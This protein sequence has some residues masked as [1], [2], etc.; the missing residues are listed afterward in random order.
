MI[1]FGNENFKKN[2]E[3]IFQHAQKL[4]LKG[5]F[6]WS[7]IL[8]SGLGP[9]EELLE[10]KINVSYQDLP[11]FPKASVEGHAG[12]LSAG[13]IHGKRVL[14][15]QGRAHIYE[16][17]TAQESVTSIYLSK[18]FG[19]HSLF[20]TNASGGINANFH[21]GDLV[22]ITDHINLSGKNPLIG[23]NTEFGPRFPD[24]THAYDVQ[25]RQQLKEMAKQLQIT[26]KEGVYCYTL[27]P[28][29]ETPAEI[30]MMGILGGDL[31]GM[32]TVPE[33]IAANHCGLK[34]AAIS[35]V[36]N[37]AAGKS[38]EK[39]NHHDVKEEA[40]KSL[41]KMKQIVARMIY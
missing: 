10:N 1:N 3:N 41:S 17:H 30:R 24:M 11:G 15:F 33:V 19:C 32:S 5:P 37:Y 16:G 8:G 25:Y 23:P 2:V 31:V 21:P 22:L 12:I 34:V 7:I 36:T 27:G 13:T 6:E 28:C 14:M 4:G 40:K 18:L 39:L 38:S 9:M 35:C 20:L 26:L 29:Y